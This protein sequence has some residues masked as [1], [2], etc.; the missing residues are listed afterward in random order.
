MIIKINH[1]TYINTDRYAV[2][3]LNDEKSKNFEAE[4]HCGMSLIGYTDANDKQPSIHVDIYGPTLK[5]DG[6]DVMRKQF[7]DALDCDESYFDAYYIAE[8]LHKENM[9]EY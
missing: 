4:C 6:S 3:Y 1:D 2:L 9:S 7:E 5:N 8:D